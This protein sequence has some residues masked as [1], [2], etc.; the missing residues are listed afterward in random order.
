MNMTIP[1]KLGH[2]W[3]GPRQPPTEWMETWKRLHREW[4][5]RLYDNNYLQ[6]RKFSTQRQ[7]NEY[8]K[9]GQYAG[10]ADLMRLEIL[11]EFGGLI[12]PADSI[13]LHSLD[14]LFTRRCAY[15]VYENEYLRGKL[16]SPIQACEP[17]NAF[18]KSLINELEK[19]HPDDLDEPWIS[20]GN[21]FTARMIDK[22]NPDITIF[23][24]HTLIPV[25]Y[26]GISYDGESKI[27]A[28][29]LFAS[30]RSSYP[31]NFIKKITY[32]GL[33]LKKKIYNNKK[34]KIVNQKK[35]EKFK[36]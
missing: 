36:A 33:E 31:G 8:L 22:Y 15:T 7:I 19:L 16:V 30:T 4:D 14:D 12:A 27:Y 20:T 32:H 28:R 2:I 13:C 23:P 34:L 1:R 6:H 24:S 18:V 25:H 10:V 11:Y 29:Q 35:S 9:R 26:T 21:L 5:Y 3:V 17:G